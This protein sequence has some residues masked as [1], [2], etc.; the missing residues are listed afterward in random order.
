M[1]AIKQELDGLSN[2]ER[3]TELAQKYD[4]EANTVRCVLGSEECCKAIK[5]LQEA[6]EKNPVIANRIVFSQDKNKLG[7]AGLMNDG[8]NKDIMFSLLQNEDENIRKMVRNEFQFTYYNHA[9]VIS[10]SEWLYVH[11]EVQVD[12]HALKGSS[13]DRKQEIIRLLREH[14]PAV[15]QASLDD[16]F[17]YDKPEEDTPVPDD[18]MEKFMAIWDGLDDSTWDI[19]AEDIL[20]DREYLVQNLEKIA[21]DIYESIEICNE[22]K[23]ERGYNIGVAIRDEVKDFLDDMGTLKNVLGARVKM[24]EETEREIPG[25]VQE[26]CNMFHIATQT[27]HV[28]EDLFMSNNESDSFIAELKEELLSMTEGLTE[29][30]D[31]AIAE[32]NKGTISKEISLSEALDDAQRR[33]PDAAKSKGNISNIN[34]NRDDEGLH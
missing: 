21:E 7:L 15:E 8:P 3:I 1:K 10:L 26:I 34:K 13:E 16:G 11:P 32:L 29:S 27:Q 18:E 14:S 4:L 17:D 31:K 25:S 20:N 9:D 5:E 2:P 6:M 19:I 23:G 28:A 22:H 30:I 24:M 12:H 33:F